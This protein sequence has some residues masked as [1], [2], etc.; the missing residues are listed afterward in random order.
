LSDQFR[1]WC[2][3]A[4]IDSKYSLHGLRHAMGDALAE[5][6][7]TPHEVASVLA[8]SSVTSALHYTQEANRKRMARK[9]TKRLF[10]HPVNDEV[11]KVEPAEC[12]NG[13]VP[14]K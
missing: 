3:Q 8:H 6:G 5:S 9:A 14:S 1:E 11:S 7:A 13:R 10:E 4:G 12:Q 2:T